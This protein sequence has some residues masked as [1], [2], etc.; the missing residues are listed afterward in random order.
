VGKPII[1]TEVVKVYP[2]ASFVQ[3]IKEPELLEYPGKLTTGELINY[4]WLR[5][6]LYRKAFQEAEADKAK[7]KKWMEE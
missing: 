7:I 6:D 1:K 3:E 2:P 4:L 5:G